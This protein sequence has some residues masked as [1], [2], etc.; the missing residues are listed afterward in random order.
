MNNVTNQWTYH[1]TIRRGLIDQSNPQIP[2]AD[3]EWDGEGDRNWESQLG[4]F[5]RVNYSYADRYLLE[6][7]V[8]RDG[9]S[10]FPKHLRWK[11]FPSFS[12][13]WVITNE[14][15]V[16]PVTNVLSFAKLRA[17]WGSIGDQ[18]VSNSLYRSILKR[19]ES[20]WLNEKG[21]KPAEYGTPSIVD[22]DITWQRIE[23]L[24]FGVDLRFLKN[25]IPKT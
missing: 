16:Q 15:F 24:D 14:P 18:T 22:S 13:G 9:S 4:F 20:K 2:L 7:N 5:G 12:A 19:G 17:S 6:A 23:T 11:T 3:G 25:E 21:M 8:R 10:K 1:T